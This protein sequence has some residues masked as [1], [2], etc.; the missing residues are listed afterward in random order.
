M[1]EMLC[2]LNSHPEIRDVVLL[3]GRDY[4]YENLKQILKN[5]NVDKMVLVSSFSKE[6]I[7][8]IQMCLEHDK[9]INSIK[10]PSRFEYVDICEFK[11]LD[12][13]W[14][15]Y[16]EWIKPQILLKV[17]NW[18]PTYF[19]GDI[20]EDYVTAFKI[21]ESYKEHTEHI[22]IKTRRMGKNPQILEWNKEDNDVELSVIF[23]MYNV[24]KYL[25]Q[26]ISSVTEWKA[27]YVEFLF[28]ND[29]SPDNSR[30][31]VLKWTQQDSRVKLLDKPNGGCA[32]ARQYGL[33]KARGKYIG[34][35]DP[36]DY[37]DESMFRKL[38]RAAMMGS[39]DISYC[40]Y[41]EY[42]E[43][44]K[45]IRKVEDTLGVPYC[46]G[47][48]DRQK[49]IDLVAYCRVAIWRGIY[50]AE[51][52]KGNNIH[53]YT[54]L[55]R[56]DDLPFKVETF[57]AAKS[58]IAVPEYLYYYRLARPGQDVSANDERLYV[59]FDIFKYLN[60]SIAGQKNAILTDHLQMCKIQTHIYAIKKIKPEL[61]E[62][63]LKHA[64]E[65]LET[66]GT[67]DRTYKLAKA[68][69]GQ[70][71]ADCY[72]AIMSGNVGFFNKVN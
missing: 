71:N 58:V 69:I 31:I 25:D 35:I 18:K 23:P 4:I 72:K 64:K 12:S 49:I 24:A 20:W 66:T 28:V 54:D 67:L 55:R 11:G 9:A 53:F 21:W 61:R 27:P 45:E 8:E 59:H 38:L 16:A 33:D 46:D 7:K 15:L 17:K 48:S 52:L 68:R 42:Y 44:T 70:E 56:F 60:E 5:I 47:T 32:S 39:Y 2:F 51:M 13:K 43:N 10:V 41:N 1:N 62:Y 63:Y 50:K 34:F 65:D 14:A 3:V 36:D 37:I 40:G 30:E 26:C 19:L 29:G 22:L 6:K 57:A